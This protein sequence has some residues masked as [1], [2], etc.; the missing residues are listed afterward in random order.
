[1]VVAALAGSFL[2]VAV[3]TIPSTD[4]LAQTGDRAAPRPK[5]RPH[6]EPIRADRAEAKLEAKMNDPVAVDFPD[7]PFKD[8][9]EYLDT[10]QGLKLQYDAAA[11]REA[12]VAMDTPITLNLKDFPLRGIF[13]LLLEPV[14]MDWIIRDGDIVVTTAS[15]ARKHPSVWR[16][17]V[18]DLVAFGIPVNELAAT[19]PATVAPQTWEATTGPGFL[20]PEE[21]ALV[22]RQTPPVHEELQRLLR[23]IRRQLSETDSQ[24]RAREARQVTTKYDV[25]EFIDPM[26]PPEKI[27]ELL[28]DAVYRATWE[29]F[30]GGG[31]IAL[32]GQT[33]EVT[34]AG[35]VHARLASLFDRIREMG[36]EEGHNGATL[37][38]PSALERAVYTFDDGDVL[39][40]ALGQS[41]AIDFM[42]TSLWDVLHRI[43]KTYG[44]VC[45]IPDVELGKAATKNAMR[46]TKTIRDLPVSSALD[47]L[48]AAFKLDW[49]VSEDAVVFVITAEEAAARRDLRVF[50]I[51]EL[52]EAG[53]S[54]DQLVKKITESIEPKSWQAA[55]GTSTIRALPGVLIVRH[56]RRAHERIAKLLES[57]A[58]K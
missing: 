32:N 50:R 14:Q 33:L 1:V 29:R 55:G 4:A 3:L 23:N 37:N 39:E 9:L 19:I 2:A 56:N 12:G 45:H 22:V 26:F 17:D 52:T 48:L 46:V 31:K 35:W 8:A 58:A 43:R 36:I 6:R 38:F 28:T 10:L 57:L 18:N 5:L 44:V 16:Y 42:D 54:A 27:V 24:R 53:R 15:V 13:K 20:S 25:T 40:G 49:Y 51:V 30:G 41:V 47:E 34:N 7:F 21:N 11:I